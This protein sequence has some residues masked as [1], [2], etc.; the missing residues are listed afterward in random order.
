MNA[1]AS[2]LDAQTVALLRRLAREQEMRTRGIRDT[3]ATQAAEIV[4]KARAEARARVQQAVLDTRRDDE[5][6]L[7]RRRAALETES[8]QVRQSILRDWLDQAWRALPAALETRWCNERARD[9]WC[10][11]AL[12]ASSRVLLHA[13]QLQIE[14]APAWLA[15]IERIVRRHLAGRDGVTITAVEGLDAGLRIRAG[16]ACVDATVH[17]LLAPRERIAAELLAQFVQRSATAPDK[18]S[19]T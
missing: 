19:A 1:T 13:E 5:Q 12:D 17:G 6:T 14:V 10:V 18:A 2:L 3:A 7:A 15:A 8:R 11:A 9:Q 4:R 16:H